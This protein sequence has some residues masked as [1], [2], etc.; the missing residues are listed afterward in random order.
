MSAKSATPP[1]DE[2][3]PR[4]L[5]MLEQT[6]PLRIN[7]EDYLGVFHDVPG[8]AL[9]ERFYTHDCAFCR[10]AKS[11]RDGFHGCLTNKRAINHLL[12]R[13]KVPFHGLC[14][15]GVTDLVHPV[16]VQGVCV[17]GVFYGSIVVRE[18]EA[19]SRVRLRA[20][21]RRHGLDTTAY[22][23]EQARLPRIQAADLPVYAERL[24]LVADLLARLID[25]SG[26]PLGRYRLER[27]AQSARERAGLPVVLQ[28]ALRHL[29]RGY[30]QPVTR[31]SV[32]N[33]IR[34]N[35]NYLSGLFTTHL[36]MTFKRYLNLLRVERAK[37]LLRDSERGIGETAYAVGFDT[38][39]YF[40]RRFKAATGLT[41]AEWRR[42]ELAPPAAPIPAE[43][44][45]PP[46]SMGKTTRP[47]SSP[48]SAR[49]GGGRP[50]V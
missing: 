34:C 32:S 9:P 43:A 26:V 47:G 31:A 7:V 13:R 28:A 35:P 33:H 41:P 2:L 21:C 50:R 18:T 5:A 19:L 14:H 6:S 4:L 15:L 10:F 37:I 30:P 46:R 24:A 11:T 40:N 22:L 44:S 36:G 48:S 1:G 39:S 38:P 12:Q 20:H 25:E 17:A 42:R 49:R 29:A 23:R 27:D 3:L 8:L 45:A 16:L